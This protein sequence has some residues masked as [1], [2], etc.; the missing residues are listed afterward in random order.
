MLNKD[1]IMTIKAFAYFS[2]L[3][4]MFV[5]INAQEEFDRIRANNESIQAYSDSLRYFE[6]LLKDQS[7]SEVDYQLAINRLSS[8]LSTLAGYNFEITYKIADS[9]TYA[10][11]RIDVNDNTM[12]EEEVTSDIGYSAADTI[13]FDTSFTMPKPKKSMM[14]KAMSVAF[15]NPANRTSIRIESSIGFNGLMKDIKENNYPSVN[16]FSTFTIQNLMLTFRTRLG[17]E[18]SK[19]GIKYG[20]GLDYVS[21]TQKDDYKL[22]NF[23]SDSTIFTSAN[24]PSIECVKWKLRYLKFPLALHYKFGK[25]YAVQ[26]G[27]FYNLLIRQRQ[28]IKS[29]DDFI[30]NKKETLETDFALNKNILGLEYKLQRK[31]MYIFFEHSLNSVLSDSAPQKLN[32]MKFGIGIQ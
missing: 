6:K 18:K 32:Y 31:R 27:G 14:G 21:L 25:K 4:L 22:L 17:R 16:P 12:T 24:N 8:E 7:I 9:V 13:T 28:I 26:V 11:Y 15:P 2:F 20:L 23:D 19:I 5:E 10:Q 1:L 29:T 30:G 3:S